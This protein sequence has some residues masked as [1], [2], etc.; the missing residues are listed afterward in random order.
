MVETIDLHLHSYYRRVS[1]GQC[2]TVGMD[3]IAELSIDTTFTDPA[4]LQFIDTSRAFVLKLGASSPAFLVTPY[5]FP[6]DSACLDPSAFSA[7]KGVNET[8][9]PRPHL[10]CHN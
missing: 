4:K 7:P 1:L 5:V 10:H 2:W 9:E 3:R 6:P 8:L